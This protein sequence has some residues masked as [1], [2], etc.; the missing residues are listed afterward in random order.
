MG[1]VFSAYHKIKTFRKSYD[2][3]LM[4]TVFLYYL[5]ED[6]TEEIAQSRKELVKMGFPQTARFYEQ[7][8]QKGFITFRVEE[9]VYHVDLKLHDLILS[10]S[11]PGHS[12]FNRLNT[13]YRAKRHLLQG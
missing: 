13:K 2:T 10:R 12:G 5:M 9:S 6:T 1:I 11:A 3:S 8:A 4:E 7:L